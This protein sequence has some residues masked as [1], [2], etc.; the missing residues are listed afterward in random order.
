MSP[1]P[2]SAL[3]DL[4][5][6]AY[7]LLDRDLV[8][9]DAN[10]AY[11]RVAGRRREQLI[12]RPLFEMFPGDPLDPRDTSAAELRASLRHVLERRE[13]HHVAFIRYP[14]PRA[15][16][17]GTVY[18]ERYWSATHT[19]VLDAD[20]EVAAILQ[21]TTEVTALHH[22]REVA[23]SGPAQLEGGVLARAQAVQSANRA[24]DAQLR[25]LRQLFDQAPGF[26]CVLRGPEHVYELVNQAYY[27]VAGRR[28][29][30]GRPIREALPELAGQGYI[31]LLDRVYAT[32]HPY[33]GHGARVLLKRDDSAEPAERYVD[34]I[35]QPLIE[36]DSTIT[37]VLV[38]GH[39]VTE[40]VTAR[41]AAERYRLQLEGV[42][43]ERTQALEASITGHAETRAQLL[44]MQKLEALGRLT[45]GVAHDFNNLLQVISNSLLILQG[46]GDGDPEIER[47]IGVARHAVRSGAN[48][49]AQLLAFARRQPLSPRS[50]NIRHLLQGMSDLIRRAIG[51]AI[52][53]TVDFA[54]GLWNIYA[55]PHQL[56]NVILNLSLNARD[57]IG[58]RGRLMLAA[59]N[60]VFA[61]DEADGPTGDCV[62]L[63]VFDT[64]HG[65]GPEVLARAFEP[66]FTTKPEGRGTGLGL[67]MVYGFVR[68][69]GGQI[70]ID[71]A[72]GMGTTV[73]VRLPRARESEELRAP[74]ALGPAPGGRETLLVVEDDEA[75]RASCAAFSGPGMT[76]SVNRRSTGS[77]RCSTRSADAASGAVSTR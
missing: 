51:E 10:P 69:S 20:G 53:V 38:Q 36:D 31:E 29:I 71:S 77:S 40:Q 57:A 56:E 46:V 24:L 12:G 37:G 48:L 23:G 5:P 25:H 1:I 66:F 9:L 58:E 41:Q 39:D 60:G 32:G 13:P 72:P 17:E 35:Y 21:H 52:E 19:P 33:V 73:T 22:L 3:F 68:Q 67:S 62:W 45:G 61:P 54:P 4:S 6:N 74:E 64:G 47:W 76:T 18:E 28:E 63:S 55:D 27:A 14:I 26:L 42:L 30:V 7:M 16:P 8:Y 49:T 65:M 11:E 44:H 34:F 15:T 70:A 75:V 43:R 59:G 2:R 50:V